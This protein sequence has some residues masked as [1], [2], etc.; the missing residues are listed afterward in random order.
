MW[1]HPLQQGPEIAEMAVP[2]VEIVDDAD[3]VEAFLAQ[4]LDDLDLVIGFAKP[5]AVVVEPQ[6]EATIRG[7][8][9]DR[10]EATDLT[11]DPFQLVVWVP[12]KPTAQTTN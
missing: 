12:S 5:S 9:G 2:V 11:L 10:K 8:F 6:F 4:S 3:I 1:Q 7:G